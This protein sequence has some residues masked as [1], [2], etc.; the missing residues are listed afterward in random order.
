MTGFGVGMRT[1]AYIPSV[2]SFQLGNHSNR[3]KKILII[4]SG[5]AGLG[6]AWHLNRCNLDITVYESDEHFGGHANTINGTTFKDIF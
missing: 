4:G 1:P 2:T 3:N 5:C 6:A